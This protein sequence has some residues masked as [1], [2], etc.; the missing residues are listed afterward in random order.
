MPAKND[1]L[2]AKVLD[3]MRRHP[4]PHTSSEIRQGLEAEG[5]KIHKT[6]TNTRPVNQALLS[7]I[8]NQNPFVERVADQTYAYVHP[9]ITMPPMERI[10]FTMDQQPLFRADDGRLFRGELSEFSLD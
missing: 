5:H 8:A 3:W 4:G 9:K 7:C 2:Q 10:G 1:G 6:K